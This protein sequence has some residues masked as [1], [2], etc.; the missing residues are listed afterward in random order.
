MHEITV[1]FCG[2]QWVGNRLAIAVCQSSSLICLYSLLY[3][4]I[5]YGACKYNSTFVQFDAESFSPGMLHRTNVKKQEFTSIWEN[6]SS[7]HWLGSQECW[8]VLLAQPTAGHETLEDSPDHPGCFPIFKIRV[9]M[10]SKIGWLACWFI[11]SLA[12]SLTHS[13]F[14][15]FSHSLTT[16]LLSLHSVPGTKGMGMAPQLCFIEW[17][18]D[19]LVRWAVLGSGS[20]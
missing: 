3:P 2:G 14:I 10:P 8:V 19:N 20:Q 7:E 16:C 17:L 12:H 4:F 15:F 11:H 18:R 1:P 6:R 5:F 13:F 9:E